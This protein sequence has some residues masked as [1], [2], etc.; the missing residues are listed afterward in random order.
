MSHPKG[1]QSS[2]S[3]FFL[4]KSTLIWI[5]V[6]ICVL[7]LLLSRSTKKTVSLKELLSVSIEA[8]RRGGAEVQVR[9]KADIGE[10]SKGKTSEGANNPVTDGDIL[11]H[12]AMYYGILKAF[13]HIQIVSEESDPDKNFD[14]SKIPQP[15]LENSEV[16]ALVL[17][18]EVVP[19][20]DV[21]VW[22]DPLDATQEYTEGLT[23]YVTTMVCVAVKG[24]PVIG[25]IYK[26]F[27]DT[28]AWGWA[29]SL[30]KVNS[31]LKNDFMAQS[32]PAYSKN[33]FIVSRSHAGDVDATAK[34]VFGED[35]K[36]TPAGGAGYKV[37]EVVKGHQDAYIHVTLIKK[38]DICPGAAILKALGGSLTS[39]KGEE[40]NYSD[41][42]EKNRG[43]VLAAIHDHQEFV[44]AFKDAKKA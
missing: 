3:P 1:R 21:D 37:W 17:S 11:S 23:Q 24:K 5:L 32:A 44:R 29:G 42:D 7:Y 10:K 20:E 27:S 41:T 13:P 30:N 35:V 38:W 26:P 43:G 16:E 18:D 34:K 14:M 25:V 19:V 9:E 15:P 40:I 22:I 8:A 39:L 6:T 2:P 36:T 28:L 4:R 33:R 31:V 12:R